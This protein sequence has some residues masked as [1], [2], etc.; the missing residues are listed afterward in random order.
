MKRAIQQIKK[1]WL[2]NLIILL[3]SLV[4][5]VAIFF[6]YFLTRS[7]RTLTEA[8]NAAALST[9]ILL[10]CGLL[11][12]M[13][14]FG[15]FDI[16]AF[17]FKQLGSMFFAKNPIRDGSYVDYKAEKTEKRSNSSYGFVAV[18]AAGLLFSIA[19]IVL[20]ILYFISM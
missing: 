16:F 4:L 5:G 18:V 1:H 19:L 2:S 6:L 9:A 15:V 8:C 20:D 13:A 10:L 3:V 17:G 14:H 12:W 7:S 11:A